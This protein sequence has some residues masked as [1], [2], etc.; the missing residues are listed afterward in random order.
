[1]SAAVICW[2]VATAGEVALCGVSNSLK[3]SGRHKG[4]TI[5]KEVVKE[6]ARSAVKVDL[7]S[8]AVLGDGEMMVAPVKYVNG[9][10]TRIRIWPS[11]RALP[12]YGKYIEGIS[13][14]CEVDCQGPMR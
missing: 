6:R 5:L 11:Q 9:V 1:V 12:A 10:P 8:D 2:G 7:H 13:E 3:A 4:L 14:R